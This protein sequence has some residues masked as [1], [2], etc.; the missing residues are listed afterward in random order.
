MTTHHIV[1]PSHITSLLCRV[2]NIC[3]IEAGS[4]KASTD[5]K[6]PIHTH[7]VV[8][9]VRLVSGALVVY[10]LVPVAAPGWTSKMA[11][12]FITAGQQTERGH[13]R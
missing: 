5:S 8:L 13:G 10:V 4:W 6:A 9:R 7:L 1:T 12:F 3:S 11:L 2:G